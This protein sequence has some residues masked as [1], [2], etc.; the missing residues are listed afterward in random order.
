MRRRIQKVSHLGKSITLVVRLNGTGP[1]GRNVA[2]PST[3]I[4]ANGSQTLTVI[5]TDVPG[6]ADAAIFPEPVRMEYTA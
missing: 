2:N 1:A 3:G 4:G 6:T 5:R